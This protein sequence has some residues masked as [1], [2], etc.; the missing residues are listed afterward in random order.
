MVIFHS[1]F[2]ICFAFVDFLQKCLPSMI[3]NGRYMKLI[4]M[5]VVASALDVDINNVDE[6]LQPNFLCTSDVWRRRNKKAV[7]HQ[8]AS[9]SVF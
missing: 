9:V 2:L 6:H 8:I 3:E 5:K 1:D 7:D 4:L